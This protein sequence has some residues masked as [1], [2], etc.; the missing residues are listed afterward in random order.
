[1][2]LHKFSVRLSSAAFLFHAAAV[3]AAAANPAAA[4][5]SEEGT[6]DSPAK[7]A[8]PAEQPRKICRT[9][10]SSSNRLG[11]KRICMTKDE[12]NHVKF[13]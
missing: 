5:A 11:A 7:A 10:E 3:P 6:A 13:D 2:H 1:M 4:P 8:K 12:W 9:I